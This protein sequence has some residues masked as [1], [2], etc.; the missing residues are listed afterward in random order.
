MKAG[1]EVAGASTAGRLMEQQSI[2]TQ[3]VKA[4]M[5]HDY[6]FAKDVAEHQRAERGTGQVNQVRFP[7]QASQLDEARLADDS[8]A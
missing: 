1:E 5:F 8:K 2:G 4:M 6:F 7:E 3:S